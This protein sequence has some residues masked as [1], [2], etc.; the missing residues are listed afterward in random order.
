MLQSSSSDLDYWTDRLRDREKCFFPT[1]NDTVEGPDSRQRVQVITPDLALLNKFC[2]DYDLK[3]GTV[4]Q[5]AW[6]LVLRSYT[7]VDDVCF[8][9][10]ED[11]HDILPSHLTLAGESGLRHA[12]DSLEAT[13]KDNLKYTAC[14]VEDIEE[15]LELGRGGIFNTVVTCSKIGGQLKS[16]TA[17]GNTNGQKVP[18][19]VVD[20][21]R[22]N[23]HEYMGNS[24][25][26]YMIVVNTTLSPTWI[27]MDLSYQSSHLSNGQA[28]NVASALERALLC[29]LNGITETVGEQ[30]LFSDYHQEQVNG[31]NRNRPE[32]TDLTLHEAIA[33]QVR[34][35]PDAL[36]IRAWDEEWTFREVD[37]LSST[38]AQHLV[39]LGVRIGMRIPLIFE[40]SGWWVVALL[41]VSKAGG[42][43][44]PVDCTQP[45]LR[46]KDI[47]K[48]VEPQ[49]LLSSSQYSTL[50][51][52]SVQT[53]VVVS[54][55][56]LEKLSSSIGISSSLPK[57]SS[58]DVAYVMVCVHANSISLPLLDTS[59]VLFCFVPPC[60]VVT[61]L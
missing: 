35:Q 39:D 45:I 8:G 25:S 40:R 16:S 44:V 43:F 55:A 22:G 17:D 2:Q 49:F 9:Y 3:L 61:V 56:A 51:A 27:Q 50:L 6:A 38:L 32:W 21:K 28:A 19:Q 31:W 60:S 14:S 20:G 54:R 24:G 18:D 41:A 26:P 11:S 29:V 47:I 7:G 34:A 53:T 52:D 58:E 1:L 59:Q 30:Y 13:W 12:L 10:A 5:A 42:A 36:A 48:D 4:F 57:V 15:A 37:E 46:I 23:E 33:T